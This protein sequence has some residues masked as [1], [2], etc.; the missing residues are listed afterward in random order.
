LQGDDVKDADESAFGPPE[1]WVERASTQTFMQALSPLWYAPLE[2]DAG[3]GVCGFFAEER[4]GNSLGVV[5]GG[6]LLTLADVALWGAAR[7][8]I[9]PMHAFTVTLNSE[10]VEGA[11]IGDWVWADGEMIRAGSKMIFGRGVIWSNDRPALMYSGT[12]KRIEKRD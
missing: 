3:N 1:D 6:A 12:L 10:F 5:H 7:R 4:H 8:K 11:K 2:A 9:G